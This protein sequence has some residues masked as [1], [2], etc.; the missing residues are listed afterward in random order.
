MMKTIIYFAIFLFSMT[1]FCAAQATSSNCSLINKSKDAFFIKFEREEV[2][3]YY[4]EKE[5]SLILRLQN[6]S[7]CSIQVSSFAVEHFREPLPPN[8]TGKDIINRM[9]K[10]RSSVEDGELVPGLNFYTKLEFRTYGRQMEPFRGSDM[11]VGLEITGGKSVLF[12][13]P[14][15]NFKKKLLVIIPFDFVWEKERTDYSS[16]CNTFHF[17]HFSYSSLPE[18]ILKEIEK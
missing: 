1:G 17:I 9:Q 3:D 2:V 10:F 7:T 12:A 13:V 16:I 15:E 18:K 14:F 8:P 11:G 6:N 5:R 4:G